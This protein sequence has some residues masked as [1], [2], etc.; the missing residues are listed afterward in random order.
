[1]GLT[2]L[3]LVF[4]FLFCCVCEEDSCYLGSA[5]GE[6]EGSQEENE[7]FD[8][9]RKDETKEMVVIQETKEEREREQIENKIDT[10]DS[11]EPESPPPKKKRRRREKKRKQMA[12]NCSFSFFTTLEAVYLPEDEG[13]EW[14]E[15]LE[16]KDYDLYVRVFFGGGGGCWRNGEDERR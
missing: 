1:M 10:R 14:W 6:G 11:I 4:S 15:M 13:G 2:W 12:G 3:V 5:L 7:V 9:E 8:R 16:K